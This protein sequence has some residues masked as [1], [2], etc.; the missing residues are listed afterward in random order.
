MSEFNSLDASYKSS[1]E[2]N[3][4]RLLSIPI[5][6]FEIISFD[7]AR[8][9]KNFS[10]KIEMCDNKLRSFAMIY[11]DIIARYESIQTRI[12]LFM[13]RVLLWKVLRKLL[14]LLNAFPDTPKA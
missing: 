2:Q 7:S 8:K 11:D 12:K 10:R 9:G 3:T 6:P 14:T 4:S 13:F 1:F 5:T